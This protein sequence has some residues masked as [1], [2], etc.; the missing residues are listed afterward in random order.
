MRGC[1]EGSLDVGEAGTLVPPG[2]RRACGAF[3]EQL[4][5][6]LEFLSPWSFDLLTFPAGEEAVYSQ[7]SF[8][9]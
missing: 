7:K 3:S 4:A 8:I 1:P 6:G 9:P 2:E 5:P